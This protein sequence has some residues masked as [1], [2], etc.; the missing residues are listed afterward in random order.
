VEDSPEAPDTPRAIE[1]T[2]STVSTTAPSTVWD[3]LDDLKSR[4]RKLELTGKLPA[5]SGAAVSQATGERPPTATTTNTTM[6]TSPKR[7]RA[8]ST[9]PAESQTI[10]GAITET[11]P[12]LHSALAKTK[13]LLPAEVYKA[14]EATASDALSMASMMGS[15]GQP[16]PMSSAQ[17]V[18][19]NSS[20]NVSE[21][22]LRRKADSMCRNLTEL[23][24]ALS[25]VKP[26]E[27]GQ[28][29]INQA[30]PRS[31][32]MDREFGPLDGSQRTPTATTDTLSRIKA[33]PRAVS[34]LEARRSSMLANSAL[35]S[36]RFASLEAST[37][38]QSGMAGRRSSLL[39]R[40]RRAGTEELDEDEQTM[41]RAP[42]RATT[43]IGRIGGSL[44][45]SPRDYAPQPRDDG[46]APSVQS[47][48]PVRRHY[49]STS[50]TSTITTSPTVS[51]I[52]GRRFLDRST[53]DRDA[54]TTVS[55]ITEERGQRQYEGRGLGRTTSMAIDRRA[56]T[57]NGTETSMGGQVGG[58]Q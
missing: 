54:T 3:E 55:R 24:L 33:S 6:S 23:C 8:V 11:H 21:R 58:F 1:G 38:P 27:Q 29:S 40:S 28:Q 32:S 50:L 51:N 44:R 53:P 57:I 37:P 22:Q 2:E 52:G 4:I 30:L 25:E 12:L 47:N 48:L 43:E 16:G 31:V 7:G 39:I 49:A 18:V 10:A 26:S 17:S 20:S 35:P 34:R 9:S 56:R 19:G 15:A 41:F 5:T 46:R 42:S 36:P 13:S 45:N 14:L